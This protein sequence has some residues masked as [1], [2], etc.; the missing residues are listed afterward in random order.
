VATFTSLVDRDL[1]ALADAFD[2]GPVRGW[3][4]IAAGTINSNFDLEAAAGRFFVRVN[5]G[6]AEADVAWEAALVT[7]LA[8]AGVATPSPRRTRSGEP[9]ARHRVG[10]SDRLVSVF[11][12]VDGHHLAADAVTYDDTQAVGAALARLHLAGATIPAARHRPSIYAYPRI[13]ERF[14]GFAGTADPAL[15]HAVA[16]IADEIAWLDARADARAALPGGIIHGDLFRDNVLF[17]GG[18]VVALIDFEQASAGTFL[19]DLSVTVNDWCWQGGAFETALVATM[20]AGYAEVRPLSEAEH[21]LFHVEA[22]AAA[23]RF[24]VTRIT[25]VH[26]AGVD[27]PDKDFRDYLARLEALR[28]TT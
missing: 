25:D 2:L 9:F 10:D 28:A 14:A 22:R 19:Y 8:A 4:P 1:D 13:K 21:A 11:P 20:V 5:E 7:D 23:M 3:R 12:W 18:R 26:L 24:T 16:V 15:A 27:K 17:D 6:K